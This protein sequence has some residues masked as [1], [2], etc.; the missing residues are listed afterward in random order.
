MLH[1]AA[2]ES[3]I[4]TKIPVWPKSSCAV[5]ERREQ[6]LRHLYLHKYL[7]MATQILKGSLAQA[8]LASAARPAQQPKVCWWKK[9]GI[10]QNMG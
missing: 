2:Q 10:G 9:G 1:S 6:P 8:S 7:K 5:G 4:W 3:Q